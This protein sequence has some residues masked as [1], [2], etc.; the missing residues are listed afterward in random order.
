MI[1]INLLPRTV[2]RRRGKLDPTLILAGLGAVVYLGVLAYLYQSKATE[3]RQL[4]ARITQARAQLAQNQAISRTVDQFK[5][6]QK[7]VEDK[8]NVIR[9]LEASQQG[10]GRVLDD[11]SRHLPGEIWLTG[12]N[13]TGARLTI[14]GFAFSTGSVADLMARLQKAGP[15]FS[16]VELSFVRKSAVEKVPVEQFEITCTIRG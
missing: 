14:Q 4:D 13:K 11:L 5:A 15:L 6:D 10:P 16:A 7:R 3:N 12:L 1:R 2:R 8:L 9:N